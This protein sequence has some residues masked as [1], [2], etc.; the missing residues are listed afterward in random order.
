[1]TNI[2]SIYERC[3]SREFV[4]EVTDIAEC[5]SDALCEHAPLITYFGRGLYGI[6]TYGHHAKPIKDVSASIQRKIAETGLVF[7]DG[8]PLSVE[9]K[10]VDIGRKAFLSPQKQTAFIDHI[11][12]ELKTAAQTNIPLFQA[13]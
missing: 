4:D 12:G 3:V 7:R 1:M 6:A 2:T 13:M 11:I 9:F 8:S 5:I 10:V